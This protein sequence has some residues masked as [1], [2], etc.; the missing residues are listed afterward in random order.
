MATRKGDLRSGAS[1]QDNCNQKDQNRQPALAVHE[2]NEEHELFDF[3]PVFTVGVNAL[4]TAVA[5]P[6]TGVAEARWGCPIVFGVPN[7]RRLQSSML[8]IV[9][10][11]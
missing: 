5:N 8:S 9:Y 6:R 4:Q 10:L 2:N 1:P 11:R 7:R 3:F